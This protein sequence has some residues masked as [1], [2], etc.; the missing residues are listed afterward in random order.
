MGRP[1][2]NNN[3]NQQSARQMVRAATKQ[4][5]GHK[6]VP[7]VRP[8][9]FVRLPWNS[10]IFSA[11]Y[12]TAP[13]SNI[14]RITVGT[15]RAQ[16]ISRMGLTGTP[17]VISMKVQTAQAWNTSIGPSFAQPSLES[18]FFELSTDSGGSY[19]V[20]SEQYDHGTLNIPARGGYLY[21]L[22]DRK[23]V[24]TSTNDSHV[25]ATFTVPSGALPN[26]NVTVRAHILWKSQAVPS[27]ANI[28]DV[29]PENP[30]QLD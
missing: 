20:R 24:H 6:I 21:P 5:H 27:L 26:G 25:V 12:A 2:R 19:S 29:I 11:T 9:Q 28:A 1:R 8:P 16:I 7:S 10:Y 3:R 13:D 4:D 15:I 23:E 30:E 18:L 14:I 22:T 17:G